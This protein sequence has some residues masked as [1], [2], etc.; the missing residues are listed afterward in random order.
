MSNK[1]VNVIQSKWFNKSPI[2]TRKHEAKFQ[3]FPTSESMGTKILKYLKN[4]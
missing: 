4:T 3:N 1:F 2:Y